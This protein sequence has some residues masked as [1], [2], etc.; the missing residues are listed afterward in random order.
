MKVIWS[1]I[2]DGDRDSI[3]GYIWLHSPR[4]AAQMDALFDM[5]TT[6]LAE[7][8]RLGKT[9]EMDGTRELLPH[10]SYRMI[11]SVE[12]DKVVVLRVLHTSRQWP[13]ASDDETT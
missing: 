2:A 1:E 11:Y 12:V 9:G 4:A 5:A 6:T 7:F 3:I 13:P 10:G 8:P